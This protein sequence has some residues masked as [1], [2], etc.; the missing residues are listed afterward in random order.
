MTNRKKQE[1]GQAGTKM[2]GKKDLELY[3]HIPFCLQKCLYCDFL[4]FP[5][6]R[7]MQAEYMDQLRCEIASQGPWYAKYQFSTIFIGG[8]TPSVLDGEQ[9]TLLMQAIKRSFVLAEDAEIR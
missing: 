9:I 4:S 3:I 7:S 2:N 8:G 5:A 6:K 1:N